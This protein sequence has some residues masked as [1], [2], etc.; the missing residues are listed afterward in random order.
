MHTF[1]LSTTGRKQS[2]HI[3]SLIDKSLSAF[4]LFQKKEWASA[5]LK[6]KFLSLLATS[7]N[8]NENM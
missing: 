3:Q 2:R 8:L 6:A 5:P 1:E 7:A 4:R